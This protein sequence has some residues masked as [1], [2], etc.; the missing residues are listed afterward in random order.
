MKISQSRPWHYFT[1]FGITSTTNTHNKH[2]VIILNFSECV[3]SSSSFRYI[4]FSTKYPELIIPSEKVCLPR[5]TC[6]NN[7]RSVQI[8]ARNQDRWAR[9]KRSESCL[10]HILDNRIKTPFC[11]ELEINLTDAARGGWVPSDSVRL[12]CFQSVSILTTFSVS[13]ALHFQDIC[14]HFYSQTFSSHIA[15]QKVRIIEKLASL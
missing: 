8:S 1:R 3:G 12:K 9:E 14:H 15:T 13:C 6:Q 2:T 11:W 5:I 4:P 10:G 7:Q